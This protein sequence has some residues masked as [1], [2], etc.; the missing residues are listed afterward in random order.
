MVVKVWQTGQTFF[1]TLGLQCFSI[2]F[3]NS[4][5]CLTKTGTFISVGRTTISP[6]SSSYKHFSRLIEPSENL[7]TKLPLNWVIFFSTFQKI[8]EVLLPLD[9]VII[10]H[11]FNG[12]SRTFFNLFI[13]KRFFFFSY[14][15]I[16]F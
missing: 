15:F 12:M 7:E 8:R 2:P 1:S 5:V 11:I 3:R 9:Y 4:T 14:H 6:V 10:I 16:P 13:G